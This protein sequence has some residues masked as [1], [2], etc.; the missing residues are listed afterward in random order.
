MFEQTS[1]FDEQ[2]ALQGSPDGIGAYASPVPEMPS[3]ARARELAVSGR[4]QGGPPVVASGTDGT[5]EF[6]EPEDVSE[7]SALRSAGFT[8]LFATL[9]LGAGIAIGGPWGAG[10]GVL[11]AGAA[12]NGYRAQKWWGSHDPSEK[13]E[14]VVSAVF[15]VFGVSLGGYMAYKAYQ[16]KK[17]E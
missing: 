17:S 2:P 10:A 7:E 16:S 5:W 9:A 15:A 6:I 14:A 12:A 1:V 4:A 11:L 3:A 8:A 13:H